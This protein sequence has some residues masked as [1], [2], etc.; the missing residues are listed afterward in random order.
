MST[1]RHQA[2]T[3]IVTNGLPAKGMPNYEGVLSSD[4]IKAIQAYIIKRANDEKN[5]K[6][7]NIGK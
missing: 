5:R 1:E 6:A 2:F 3:G 7:V 4:E